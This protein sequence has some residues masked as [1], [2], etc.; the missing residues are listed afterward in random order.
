MMRSTEI[1]MQEHQIILQ[2]MSQLEEDLVNPLE[3]NV[4]IIK[5]HCQFIVDFADQYHHAKEEEIYFKWMLS[6]Q[7]QLELG[8]I[9]C[10]LNEHETGRN[11]VR[12][13]I[14]AIAEF[15]TGK[16]ESEKVAK[17]NLSEFV[18]HITMHIQKEDDILYKMAESIDSQ[19][20]DGDCKMLESFRKINKNLEPTVQSFL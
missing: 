12:A 6:K 2:R 8:P 20:G 3:D 5:L 18:R 14:E 16:F 10:M 17:Q 9:K 13:A 15:E 1:L 7:P 4:E 11:F 19:V